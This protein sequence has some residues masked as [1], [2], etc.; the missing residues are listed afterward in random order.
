VC[1]CFVGIL[2]VSIFLCS[3]FWV[4]GF[5]FG[6]EKMFAMHGMKHQ[7]KAAMNTSI[8][9]GAVFF[10]SR[11]GKCSV[12]P[13]FQHVSVVVWQTTKPTLHFCFSE[14]TQK[15]NT[16]TQQFS[17]RIHKEALCVS[18]CACLKLS[19]SLCLWHEARASLCLLQLWFVMMA[20]AAEQ[21]SK[22][23]CARRSSLSP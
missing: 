12:K 2:C 19:V 17:Q 7:L 1:V 23:L 4:L 20:T 14:E 9:N 3:N 6:G 21:A 15:T 18:L 13:P 10:V 5:W 8:S 16:P 22:H 11:I